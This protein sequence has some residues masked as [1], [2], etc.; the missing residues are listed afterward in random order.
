M[1]QDRLDDYIDVDVGKINKINPSFIVNEKL[2]YLIL[3][4]LISKEVPSLEIQDWLLKYWELSNKKRRVL[5][6]IS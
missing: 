5:K 4:D 2:D 3:G 6:A 1:I